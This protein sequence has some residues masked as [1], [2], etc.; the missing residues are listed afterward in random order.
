MFIVQVN[1]TN[2]EGGV[3]K[4]VEFAVVKVGDDCTLHVF[5]THRYKEFPETFV[6][7]M[8]DRDEIDTPLDYVFGY[9]HHQIVYPQQ[10]QNFGQHR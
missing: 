3:G 1:R 10:P 5:N 4:V 6:A 9:V 8:A 7:D 2:S